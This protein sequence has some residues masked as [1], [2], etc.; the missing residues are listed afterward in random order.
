MPLALI[1]LQ[2]LHVAFLWLHD[3]APLPPWNDVAAARRRDGASK[4]AFITVASAAPFTLGLIFSLAY[5]HVPLP[6][7]VLAWLWGTYG[8]LFAGAL[9]AWWWP[10]L[11]G[12]DQERTARRQELF[13]HTHRF[14]PPRNGLAPDTLHFAYHLLI[15]TT[16]VVLAM[17]TVQRFQQ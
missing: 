12:S 3:W 11:I 4:L 7:W 1:V 13:G 9:R 14:L 16:L 17:V 10:Y 8:L 5:R 2:V 15:A 6:I